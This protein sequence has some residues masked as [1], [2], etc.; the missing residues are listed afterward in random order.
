MSFRECQQANFFAVWMIKST[1]Y[2]NI[3]WSPT[4]ENWKSGCSQLFYAPFCCNRSPIRR[5]L[6][7]ASCV[8]D[9]FCNWQRV[10]GQLAVLPRAY[11]GQR[12]FL[13]TCDPRL[14]RNNNAARPVCPMQH[15]LNPKLLGVLGLDLQL[16]S[17]RQN[18][19]CDREKK[20]REVEY[21]MRFEE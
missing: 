21:F 7:H 12:N 6:K 4:N 8:L 2:E 20:T 16:P 17:W 11:V 10:Q 15:G 3:L 18:R 1:S 9:C 13:Q 14:D 19:K 5:C